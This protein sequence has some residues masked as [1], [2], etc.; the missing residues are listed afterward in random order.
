M[1]G[2]S[3]CPSH[4]P[5]TPL[6]SS[7]SQST[8]SS[9]SLAPTCQGF[10]DADNTWEPAAHLEEHQHLVQECKERPIDPTFQKY[11]W[12][13]KAGKPA[14]DAATSTCLTGQIDGEWRNTTDI[15][16]SKYYKSREWK[17]SNGL[18]IFNARGSKLAQNITSAAKAKRQSN[19]QAPRGPGPSSNSVFGLDSHI[20]NVLE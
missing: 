14:Q 13:D 10:T 18:F 17:D 9:H 1:G 4:P 16:M 8:P 3:H 2:V 7:T 20:D 12:H 5:Q 15:V 6:M 11:Y 19:S